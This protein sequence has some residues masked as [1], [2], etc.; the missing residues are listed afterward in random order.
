M[1]AMHH[2]DQA[3]GGGAADVELD[4][5]LRVD[6]E[7]DIGRCQAGAAAGGDEDLGEDGQQEDRLDQDHDGDRRGRG[8]AG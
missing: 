7:G 8:A 4:Q 2:G 5:R 3:A 1:L 6:Q